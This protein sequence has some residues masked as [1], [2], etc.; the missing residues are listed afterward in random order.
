VF[1]LLLVL[2]L[3]VLVLAVG[4]AYVDARHDSTRLAGERVEAV[5][6]SVARTPGVLSALGSADPSA[7]LQ[8]YAEDV[9]RYTGV[10]FVVVM[11]PDRTR[12]SHPTVALI[13]R[14]FI[15]TIPPPPSGHTLPEPY[16][17]PLGPSVRAVSPVTDTGGAIVGLV[18]VGITQDA[19]GSDVQRALPGLLLAALALLAVTVTGAVLVVR[20]LRRV[21]HGLGPEELGRMYA[22]YDAVLHSVREGLVLVDRHGR[23][24]L[25]NDEARRLLDLPVDVAGLDATAVGLPATLSMLLSSGRDV[26]DEI[27][28][29]RARVVVVSSAPAQADGRVLG[30]VMTL[31]DHTEVEEL[32]GELDTA[33]GLAEALRSQAHEAANRLHAV[34]SLVELGRSDDAIELATEELR[35]AQRLTD[36]LLLAVDEPVV[37]ALLL[38]KSAVA[39]ERGIELVVTPDTEVGSASLAP[40]GI[41]GRDVVTLLGNLLDN[42]VDAAAESPPPR[43]VEVTVRTGDGELLIRVADT[44]PGLDPAAAQLA[45]RRGWSSKPADTSRLHGRG[46]G[47]ALVGQTVERLGGTIEVTRKVGAVFTVRVPL[48]PAGLAPPTTAVS[49]PG[50]VEPPGFAPPTTAVSVA[51]PVEIIA[52]HPDRD[53][54][55]APHPD[56]DS[57]GARHLPVRT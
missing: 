26:T 6:V 31:R 55:G 43:R 2:V 30:R 34:I 46:L 16:P 24:Q 22:Y 13:G 29:T 47:L 37:A 27:H 52:P 9:R 7:E 35:A 8:P 57:S 45:F 41:A 56:R 33:R 18:A 48:E 36:Q 25:A 28:L 5:A 20:R 10:D 39:G 49:G 21:T 50:S 23:L 38:G 42:A 51:D 15:G 14:P 19:I 3:V 32:A 53:S 17:A 40:R 54:N 1:G 44:G 11:A 12:F 4:L